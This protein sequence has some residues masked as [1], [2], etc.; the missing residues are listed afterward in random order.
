MAKQSQT[1]LSHRTVSVQMDKSGKH[2]FH[3]GKVWIPESDENEKSENKK[4]RAKVSCCVRG[5]LNRL[6]VERTGC[7]MDDLFESLMYGMKVEGIEVSEKLG[8]EGI[9]VSEKRGSERK[10]G[11]HHKSSH[12]GDKRPREDILMQEREMWMPSFDSDHFYRVIY[13][14]MQTRKTPIMASAALF[15]AVRLRMPVFLFVQNR[16]ADLKQLQSR[17]DEFWTDWHSHIEKLPIQER[18]KSDMVVLDPERGKLATQEAIHTA[19]HAG[20]SQVFVCLFNATDIDP[21]NEMVAAGR[22]KRYAIVL[23]ESDF[24]DS[25][26]ENAVA[27]SFKTFCEH[28]A[29]VQNV[30]AT[31]LTTLAHRV[32]LRR[33]FISFPPPTGYKGLS[34]VTWKDLPFESTPCNHTNDNPFDKD[35]NLVAFLE[36]YHTLKKAP[37]NSVRSKKVPRYCLMRLGRTIEPQ[38]KAATY[39]HSRYPQTIVIT[40]NGGDQGTTMRSKLLPQEPI[41][42]PGTR[43]K[44]EYKDGVHH[45]NSVHIG[46]LIS[47]LHSTGYRPNGS[48]CFDRIIVYAGVMADRGITFGADNYTYCKEKGLPWW[49][50]TDLYYIGSKNRTVQNL[51]NVL[52][53]CGRICGVYEDNIALSLYS[54]WVDGVREAY[55]LQQELLDRVKKIGPLDENILETMQEMQVSTAKKVRK[56]RVT[57]EHVR[58]P[59]KWIAGSDVEYGGWTE[60]QRE[61]IMDGKRKEVD[62]GQE[63]KEVEE[64]RTHGAAGGWRKILREK[65]T[66]QGKKLYDKFVKF[67]ED[68]ENGYGLGL[69]INKSRILESMSGDKETVKNTS[70]HWHKDGSSTWK[71]C[72]ETDH[73][74]LFQF[75]KQQNQWMV[76]YN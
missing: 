9:E 22:L 53:A 37:T 4:I 17:L 72:Q 63:K 51:A 44:S 3:Q 39:T 26:A 42:L 61:E 29:F 14:D 35:G 66:E 76:R 7:R 68:E 13:S 1:E 15:V 50:L 20:V 38:L 16:K 8:G 21:I 71:E 2:I 62:L 24:L 25:G 56:I 52:Q 11:E 75:N 47:Y 10:G 27:A 65:L 18:L 12:V 74:L 32:C 73:G 57:N 60:E 41:Q 55:I 59:L 67:F 69:V 54:N 6:S 40:W 48:L 58:D 46:T 49:H 33:H 19:M 70:W 23:D 31:P 36:R 5:F 30:T 34:Q 45:F 64:E 43:I 28:A